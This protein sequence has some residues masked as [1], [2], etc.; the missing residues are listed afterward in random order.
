MIENQ[1]NQLL[2]L[3]YF[4]HYDNGMSLTLELSHAKFTDWTLKIT[5]KFD[6]II[7]NKNSYYLSDLAKEGYNALKIWAGQ[8]DDA[9]RK[10][11]REYGYGF[12]NI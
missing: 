1:L 3:Y 2:A 5:D 12:Y 10:K 4:A 6:G 8:K 7:F 9:W 11:F